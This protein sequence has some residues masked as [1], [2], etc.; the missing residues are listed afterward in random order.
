MDGDYLVPFI[1][2]HGLNA[3]SQDLPREYVVNGSFY[4]ISPAELLAYRS[5]VGSKTM[6]LIIESPHEEMDIDTKLDFK[7]A[8]F[9]VVILNEN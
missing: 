4:L 1:Q 7:I 3:R 9:I 6:P 2:E 8:E 5:F